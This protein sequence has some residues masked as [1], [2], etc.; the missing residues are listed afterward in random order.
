MRIPRHI[1]IIPDGNRRWALK[2]SKEKFEGYKFG[3]DPGLRLFRMACRL[4]VEELTFYGFTSDNC[5][6]EK[7]QRIAFSKACV[8]SVNLIAKE[9][10]EILVLGDQGSQMFP[11][12]LSKY[13]KR[14]RVNSGGIRVNF[15]IN[16]SW[17][18]DI[19]KL[20]K[21]KGKRKDIC[22]A[23]QSWDI[24]RIDLIIRW[25][26]MNRLS[27]F[28]P[29]QSVYS[30]IFSCENLWPDFDESDISE[31]IKWYQDQDQTLGG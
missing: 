28:L 23:I 17:D 7:K 9:D 31:A 20:T 8:D 26:K 3:I 19:F 14:T 25:G 18:W 16:Y 22:K 5:K 11:R 1:G 30:D 15:L 27:G 21:F 10:A 6:R 2:H 13:T 4:G 24:S 29:V 12:E